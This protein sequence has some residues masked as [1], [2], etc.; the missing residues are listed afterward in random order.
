[1]KP[2]RIAVLGAGLIGR[3]H[4]QTIL[5]MPQAA[6]LVAVADP[7]AD[8]QQLDLGG[9]AWFTDEKDMLERARPEAVVIATP[10]GL[11]NHRHFCHRRQSTP[12]PEAPQPPGVG[13]PGTGPLPL[14]I[15]VCLHVLIP[16]QLR[17]AGGK[18]RIRG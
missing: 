3:R 12:C 11:Q 5:S 2:L 9:A 16:L 4:I 8:P 15:I 17:H 14:L 18:C 10:N 7:V 6:E 1:M 13:P